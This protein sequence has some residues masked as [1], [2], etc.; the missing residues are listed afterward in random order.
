MEI[1]NHAKETFYFAFDT[2]EYRKLNTTQNDS[3][4]KSL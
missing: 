1:K 4:C 2:F 3:I